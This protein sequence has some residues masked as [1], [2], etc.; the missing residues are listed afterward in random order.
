[1]ECS[2]RAYP[3]CSGRFSTQ[4]RRPSPATASPST[5]LP[6]TDAAAAVIGDAQDPYG[7]VAFSAATEARGC[8][9]AARAAIGRRGNKGRGSI[10]IVD[11]RDRSRRGVDAG[12]DFKSSDDES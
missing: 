1:M 3:P 9:P 10:G 12:Q 4:T 2:P 11:W 5:V 6:A 8:I 7:A